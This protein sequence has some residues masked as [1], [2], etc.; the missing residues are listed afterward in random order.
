MDLQVVYDV[1]RGAAARLSASTFDVR[2]SL[3]KA[4]LRLPSK[5]YMEYTGLQAFHFHS[6]SL[7]LRPFSR[8]PPLASRPHRPFAGLFHP[9]V[10][11]SVSVIALRDSCVEGE[12]KERRVH[13]V[14]SQGSRNNSAT[15]TFKD[16]FAE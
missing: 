14:P 15:S 7:C 1:T 13:L 5:R 4:I 8:W 6:L 10:R 11:H 3:V 12:F 16:K 9:P 2:G